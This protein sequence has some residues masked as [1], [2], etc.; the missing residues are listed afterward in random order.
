MEEEEVMADVVVEVLDVAV[1]AVDSMA[2]ITTTTQIKEINR[3]VIIIT[4]D[5]SN[6]HNTKVTDNINNR[7]MEVMANRVDSKVATDFNRIETMVSS[8]SNFNLETNIHF[9]ASQIFIST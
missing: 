7:T 9:T 6:N 8:K 5:T 2:V 4:K 1:E 3:V